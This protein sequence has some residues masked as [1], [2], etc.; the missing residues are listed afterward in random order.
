VNARKGFKTAFLLLFT[1]GP[2]NRLQQ[3]YENFYYIFANSCDN[4]SNLF[5]V[6]NELSNDFCLCLGQW[7]RVYSTDSQPVLYAIIVL[8]IH[9]ILFCKPL[10]IIIYFWMYSKIISFSYNVLLH[11]M[12]NAV[13]LCI[14]INTFSYKM[15][16]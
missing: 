15:L 3:I 9:M 10:N 6:T 12:K 7:Q 16:L 8:E 13:K 14:S 5:F 1:S 11:Q 2:K 4:K